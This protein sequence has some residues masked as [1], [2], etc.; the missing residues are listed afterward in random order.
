MR[1]P[2]VFASVECRF[3][4]THD[5]RLTTHD[6]RLM[7]NQPVLP[8]HDAASARADG[9]V[10]GDDDEGLSVF[11]VQ[12]LDQ[13]HHHGGGRAVEVA[14]R[15]V[16][17]DDRGGVD[18]GTG[19]A[20]ALLLPARELRRLVALPALHAHGRQHVA[21]AAARLARPG[22]GDQQRQFDVFHGVQ[23]RQQ[24]ERLEDKAHVA[25]A[26]GGAAA[27]T[28]QVQRLAR[29]A[30]RAVVDGVEPGQAVEQRGLTAAAMA[31][32]R[33]DLAR[34]H[35]QADAAQGVD[36]RPAHAV[37]LDQVRGLDDRRH[38]PRPTKL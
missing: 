38:C 14:G 1:K 11:A 33:H 19:D 13:L 27:I 36:R 16:G 17:P 8:M 22:T 2:V 4:T 3:L 20:R 5:F 10:V 28:H 34:G 32:D 31:H 23:H 7:T 21:R 37:G 9:G 26:V 30:D 35:L 12:A 6:F 29:D 18:E 15:L 24:I 25:R